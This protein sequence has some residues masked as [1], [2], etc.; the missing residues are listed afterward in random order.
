[1]KTLKRFLTLISIV[2]IL[3][4]GFNLTFAEDNVSWSNASSWATELLM[5]AQ[6]E[7]M[8]PN[9]L[10]GTD[11]KDSINRREFAA[12][13]VKLYERLSGE[14]VS[15]IGVNPFTDT[16][17]VEI[18]KAYNLGITSGTS[19]TTFSPKMLLTREQAAT[20]LTNVIR[21]VNKDIDTDINNVKLFSDDVNISSWA[22]PS[23]YFMTKNGIIN[24]IGNNIFAPR[25]ITQAQEDAKYANTT[26]EQA[27]IISI[28]SFEKLGKAK[29]NEVVKEQVEVH[30]ID[31]GQA[32]A[33]LIKSLN[34][35]MLID[36]GN[37][38]DSNLIINYLEEFNITELEYVIA[39]HPHE[40]H[41]GSLDTI[42]NN[43]EIKNL[44]MPEISQNTKAFEDVITAIENKGLE[45]TAPKVGEKY[46]LGNTEFIIIAPNRLSYG[47]NINNYSVGIRLICGEN[48]FIFT[49][50][51]EAEAE[52]D[53]I[54][55]GI[56]LKADVLKLGHH[57][58]SSSSSETF[59]KAVSPN[60]AVIMCG[61]DNSYGHPHQE[62]L[63]R[64]KRNNIQLFRT[65]LQ[66]SIIAI[67]DGNKITWST[68][69]TTDFGDQLSDEENEYIEDY[70]LN[71]NSKKF[72]Y[73]Y[74]RSAGAIKESNKKEF[75]GT[76]EEIIKLGYDPCGNC[77]P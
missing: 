63:E 54:N 68:N 37:N 28:K 45:I 71:T 20:M 65:D 58:S 1:M 57:G 53:I 27:L 25:N 33:I 76:R 22:R 26:R 2:F 46:T 42:I 59:I 13:A 17:D 7:G 29:D 44:I 40:D 38:A 31:V 39:T 14:T 62:T 35:F 47:D 70:I 55:T 50:D 32:D 18:I 15:D 9:C 11:M 24:G 3:S 43:F 49:G 30:F 64:L 52:S 10:I 23:V 19:D 5:Q 16:E 66:G 56:S 77:N 75:T 12:V 67:S 8:I 34:E 36:A 69:P 61:E 6:K 51:A 41:I 4:N 48:S 74:C 73:T 72:H 60:Y 21:I